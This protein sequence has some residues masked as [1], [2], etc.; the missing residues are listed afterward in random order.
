MGNLSHGGTAGLSLTA[1][2]L[3]RLQPRLLWA[4]PAVLLSLAPTA[5]FLLI[6]P[7]LGGGSSTDCSRRCASWGCSRWW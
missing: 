4:A 6:M 5:V 2:L 3:F 1:G 7:E